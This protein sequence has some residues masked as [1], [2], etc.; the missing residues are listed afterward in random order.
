MTEELSGNVLILQSGESTVVSNAIL[1]GTITESLNHSVIEEVYGVLGG[2]PGIC[3]EDFIDLAE[4][5]QQVVRGLRYTPGTA[6]GKV[7][8]VLRNDDEVHSK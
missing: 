7:D 5:S 2:F 3:K 8:L 6:L 1:A 4:E